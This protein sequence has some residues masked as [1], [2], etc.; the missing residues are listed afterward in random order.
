MP[1]FN[2]PPITGIPLNPAAGNPE[3][4][5]G[6][7]LSQMFNRGGEQEE[8]TF[9]TTAGLSDIIPVL[10]GGLG[11]HAFRGKALGDEL[12]G[13]AKGFAESRL[14][15]IKEAR[16]KQAEHDNFMLDQAHKAMGDID[17][18]DLASVEAPE[19]IKSKIMEVKDLYNRALSDGKISPK[20]A[21][22]I[23]TYS[24]MAKQ[25]FQQAKHD[26]QTPEAG[27]KRTA[28]SELTLAIERARNRG[29]QDP[30]TSARSGLLQQFQAEQPHPWKDPESGQEVMLNPNDY[31]KAIREDRLREE[32]EKRA[33]TA[34]KR[35][36]A[37]N[38]RLALMMGRWDADTVNRVRLQLARAIQSA[39]NSATYSGAKPPEIEAAMKAAEDN[40]MRSLGG[41]ISL[42]SGKSTS[43]T[44]QV[45][46]TTASIEKPKA[47][48]R[49]NPA[50]GKLEDIK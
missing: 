39:A 9:R 27:A 2:Q 33:D 12:S 34:L 28:A 4:G 42:P 43:T 44:T 48:K 32:G 3:P 24:A 10:L 16:Q 6:S 23:M 38:S 7:S 31:I 18:L 37:Y 35:A 5:R 8:P 41:S 36:A 46:P 29:E 14:G 17:G 30:E 40:F 47:T 22:E 1:L 45:N 15:N 25:M 49:F 13:F 21:Q 11:A 19:M 20:E 26:T 50:T